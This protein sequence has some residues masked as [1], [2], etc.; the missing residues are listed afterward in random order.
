MAIEFKLP[1]LGENVES[2]AVVSVLVKAGDTI[3]VDEPVMEIETDKAVIEVPSGVAGKIEK[4]HFKEG[5]TAAVGQVV[6]TVDGAAAPPPAEKETPPAPEEPPAVAEAPAETPSPAAVPQQTP[7]TQVAEPAP[8]PEPEPGPRPAPGKLAPAAPSVRRF[9]R[10]LGLDIASV[11]GSGTG[12]RISIDD[13]KNFSRRINAPV[14]DAA[15]SGLASTA[16]LPE[17]SK[18]GPIDRQPMS[19]VRRITAERMHQ[20][21]T[22]IPHVTQFDKAD[23][24]GFEE[25]RTRYAKRVEAA[26]GKL[27]VTAA[28]LKILASALKV[29]PQFNASIDMGK[30]EIIH[31]KYFNVGV[32]VDTERG[33]LV[34]VVKDVDTKNILDLCS[35]LSQISDK[36][37][38]G[39]ITPT[40]MQGGCI[41][42]TNLGGIGGTYFTPIVN[43]PEVAILAVSRAQVE[44]VHRDEEFVPRTLLP[45]ALSYDHR[46]IDGADG[47]RFLR[48]VVG[49]L[50]DPFLLNL[51]G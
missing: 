44:L 5:Q 50:E 9:A 42:I 6:L 31:K 16:A 25:T 8:A 41:T 30:R 32:A 27:T 14:Q 49:A 34:P 20:A 12:G 38:R 7:E 15:P 36:A 28:L 21:W 19:T 43:A 1:E 4:V 33:L 45:L 13:V 11:P 48:W 23:I 46:V 51:E 17:F 37:R 39:R 3:A 35:E 40:E 18:W 29:F 10:E 2:G 22:A 47:A 24:T 26:G